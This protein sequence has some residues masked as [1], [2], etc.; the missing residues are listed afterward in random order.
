MSEALVSIIVPIYNAEKYIS[1]CI[2][3]ALNQTY[4]NIELVLINDGSPD[5]SLS[6][7]QK[8]EKEN[9]N[10]IVRSTDNK[11]VC[12]ARNL[13]LSLANGEYVMFLDSDDVLTK[14]AVEVLYNDL[15]ENNADIAVGAVASSFFETNPKLEVWQGLEGFEKC[16][17]DDENTY[18]S[19]GKLYNKKFIKDVEFNEGRKIHED[20][21]F[22]F[23]C[24]SKNP[25]IT[26][27]NSIVYLYTRNE[28]SASHAS[29][30]EKFYDILYF[31]KRK[32]EIINEIAPELNEKAKNIWVKANLA[33]LHQFLNTTDKKY[34]ADEKDCIR[35]V[36]KNKKYF[37]P[38][39][40]GD[41]KFFNIVINNLYYV[42]K[43]AYKIKYKK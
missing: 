25:K 1:A 22:V 40:A 36:K 15:K 35:E 38:A 13:G 18:S 16:I 23:E 33:M 2:E 8:Y 9:K 41:Q 10:V 3:S 28:N 19:C 34:K 39:I 6:I 14:N 5:N 24:F 12:A 43:L 11:G 31:A 42:F 17:L 4:E 37:I 20:A 27:N 7:A 32:L 29:F 30:S 21:F 26:I